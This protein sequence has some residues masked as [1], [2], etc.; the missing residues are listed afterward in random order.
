MSTQRAISVEQLLKMKFDVMEF[1]GKY[2]NSFGKPELSGVWL[3]WAHSG[4]GK[5]HFAL[6]LAKYLTHFGKVAYNT[7]EEGARLTFQMAAEATNIREVSGRFTVLSRES[8]SDLTE[9]LSK[10]K[11]P[12]IIFIDSFQYTG[13]TKKGYI[14]LKEKFPKKLFVFVSHAE[15]K[16]PEGRTAKFVRYDADIKI[17]VEGYKAFPVSRYGGNEEFVIWDEG[18]YEYWNQTN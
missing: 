4:N 1:E 8:I 14:A 2:L 9:R 12:D 5:T 16:H 15:G 13:L 18:A 7:M 6:Q 10:R 11:S 17:R 3:I